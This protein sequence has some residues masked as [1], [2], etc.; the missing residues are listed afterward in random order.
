VAPFDMPTTT[1]VSSDGYIQSIAAADANDVLI[2]SRLH[3]SKLYNQS[4]GLDYHPANRRFVKTV[5]GYRDWWMSYRGLDVG[6]QKRF[7][8]FVLHETLRQEPNR[9][10]RILRQNDFGDWIALSRDETIAF[11]RNFFDRLWSFLYTPVRHGGAFWKGSC[12]SRDS[13]A[14]CRCLATSNYS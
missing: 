5:L 4:W 2:S 12:A 1:I 9:I 13:Q 3:Y 11:A 7:M 14:M 8:V 6:F 10:H